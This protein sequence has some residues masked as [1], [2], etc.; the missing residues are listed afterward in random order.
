MKKNW[1]LQTN[2]YVVFIL[3]KEIWEAFS[4]KLLIPQI[5]KTFNIS[6]TGEI[7]EFIVEYFHIILV[8]ILII[9][10]LLPALI[11]KLRGF[12]EIIG[13]K[14][15]KKT[16]KLDGKNF[17]ECNF[18]DCT[19]RWNGDRKFIIENCHINGYKGF[20]TPNS[21]ISGTVKTLRMLHLLDKEFADSWKS[22]PKEYFN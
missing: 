12:E 4:N 9:S 18:T 10:V 16:I 19:F 11:L 8:G 7:I 21:L 15:D 20:E 6:T 2:I 13:V 5:A 17:I 22:K 3:I 1:E 14:F